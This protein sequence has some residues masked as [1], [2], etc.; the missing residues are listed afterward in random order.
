MLSLQQQ[1]CHVKISR[2]EIQMVGVVRIL[3][4]S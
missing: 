3:L 2:K 4:A 1:S